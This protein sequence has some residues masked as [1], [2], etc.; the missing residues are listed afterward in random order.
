M[1]KEIE[2]DEVDMKDLK[3]KAVKME[4][5]KNNKQ[6]NNNLMW[7]DK[8]KPTSLFKIYLVKFDFIG[9]MTVYNEIKKI[10]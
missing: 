6:D 5:N 2:V 7:V 1:K 8:Y 10:F 4:N 3:M 9:C